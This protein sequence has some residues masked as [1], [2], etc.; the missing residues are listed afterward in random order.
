MTFTKCDKVII[1]GHVGA[2]NGIL[3]NP[4][5]ERRISLSSAVR[6]RLSAQD[7]VR[8][9]ARR[10]ASESLRTSLGLGPTV[11]DI[12]EPVERARRTG[13]NSDI[14]VANNSFG[15]FCGGRSIRSE[16]RSRFPSSFNLSETR[17]KRGFAG[18]AGFAEAP[19]LRVG[20]TMREL[21]QAGKGNL[22]NVVLF[23]SVPSQVPF[24]RFFLGWEG[25]PTK[26]D[27]RKK[28]YLYSNLSTGGPSWV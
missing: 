12:M 23:G 9:L 11:A 13:W 18:F 5:Y 20:F 26:I 6:P 2:L 3:I 16:V 14:L 10:A 17:T 24:Y 22:G 4:P 21:L 27:Y 28:G 8:G 7:V 25:S 15:S 1:H 19:R